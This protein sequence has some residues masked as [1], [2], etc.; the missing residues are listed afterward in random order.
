LPGKPKPLADKMRARS[1]HVVT[2]DKDFAG[3]PAGSRLLVW[4]PTEVAD[5]LRTQVPPGQ[6]PA[7]NVGHWVPIAPRSMPRSS[8][9]SSSGPR[10]RASRVLPAEASRNERVRPARARAA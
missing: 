1:P 6:A 2:L 10:W 4:C 9:G 8:H 5:Y 7:L 3:V